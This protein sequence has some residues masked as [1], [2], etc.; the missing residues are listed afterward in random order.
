M[1]YTVH[2]LLGDLKDMSLKC[3]FYSTLQPYISISPLKHG[4]N[5]QP[6]HTQLSAGALP[7]AS[8]SP[9]KKN[10]GDTEGKRWTAPCKKRK[11][12]P[13]QL[14]KL[15]QQLLQAMHQHFFCYCIWSFAITHT[16]SM[17][18]GSHHL[19]FG[20]STTSLPRH[21]KT[22]G[23]HVCVLMQSVTSAAV[24]AKAQTLLQAATSMPCF[25]WGS[26]KHYLTE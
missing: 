1:H 7:P 19:H 15:H 16:E 10:A 6:T 20:H 9:R 4:V 13:C 21:P 5:S 3:N 24:P 8:T 12:S 2:W 25:A 17:C 23:Q 18:W 14:C 22:S 11:V 26:R